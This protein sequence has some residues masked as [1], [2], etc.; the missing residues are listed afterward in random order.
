MI[1]LN[2]DYTFKSSKTIIASYVELREI[3][4]DF[5]EKEMRIYQIFVQAKKDLLEYA[6]S[7]EY[8]EEAFITKIDEFLLAEIR[9][10]TQVLSTNTL[11]SMD[12]E[13]IIDDACFASS[14]IRMESLPE[15]GHFK[16]I[17]D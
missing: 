6:I 11:I 15:S 3:P 1:V 7:R 10:Q 13:V 2:I 4:D 8:E 9:S 16:Y 14:G 17:L 12:F 5:D